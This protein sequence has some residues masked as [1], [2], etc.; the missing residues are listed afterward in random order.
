MG[1]SADI[2]ASLLCGQCKNSKLMIWEAGAT[3]QTSATLQRSGP[4]MPF[5]TVRCLWLKSAVMAP[6]KL[7]KCEGMAR[8]KA[9]DALED[10]DGE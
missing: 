8:L 9:S 6:A 1:E 10:E 4:N 2:R 5:Y 3:L 7:K